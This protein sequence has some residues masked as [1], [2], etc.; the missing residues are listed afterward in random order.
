M[1]GLLDQGYIPSNMPQDG[2]LQPGGPGDFVA[3][4]RMM[5]SPVI[6]TG[7][8]G[9]SYQQLQANQNLG[10]LSNILAQQSM[11]QAAAAMSPQIVGKSPEGENV[12]TSPNTGGFHDAMGNAQADPRAVM[13]RA[14]LAR[15]DQGLNPGQSSE[16]Q[17]K[18]NAMS[19][20]MNSIS[21]LPKED[22]HTAYERAVGVLAGQGKVEIHDLP[23]WENG[24][25]DF[26]MKMAQMQNQGQIAVAN[27]QAQNAL[28]LGAQTGATELGKAQISTQPELIKSQVMQQAYQQ[29]QQPGTNPVQA[30]LQATL[31]NPLASPADKESAMKALVAG[32]M[33][34]PAGSGLPVGA[35]ISARAATTYASAN[36]GL[37]QVQEL[38]DLLG[39]GKV[40][41]IEAMGAEKIP[42]GN[43]LLSPEN[44]RFNTLRLALNSAV[45]NVKGDPSISKDVL[46]N[47]TK[48][49]PTLGDTKE[50]IAS[51]IN[52]LQ[53]H[54]STM[55]TTL[56][57][58]GHIARALQQQSAAPSA[59]A[60]SIPSLPPG[61]AP[62]QWKQIIQ[63]RLAKMQSSAAAPQGQPQ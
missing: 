16:A 44:Q 40:N 45:N 57:P 47:L 50:E 1:S 13:Q 54:F 10:Q 9:L 22:Q 51:K 18:S 23:S 38:S 8:N 42:G 56:D 59:Q 62:D 35:P 36:Q 43:A 55:K 7:T 30:Q 53:G 37:S 31:N 39:S 12:W 58:D 24:G 6:N 21:T 32:G 48:R 60:S 52:D 19:Q 28:Q 46:D 11:Q 14:A 61:V 63:M 49:L 20:L 34:G 3:R 29:P 5:P 4:Q 17:L 25:R 41:P 33:T 2:Q 27:V 26:M 15:A